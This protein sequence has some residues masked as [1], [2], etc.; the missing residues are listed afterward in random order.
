MF[1]FALISG[2]SFQLNTLPFLEVSITPYCKFVLYS[3][4]L[5]VMN[6]FLDECCLIIF[7]RLKLKIESPYKQTKSS[8]IN[9]SAVLSCPAV[10]NCL[11]DTA[12]SILIP[13]FFPS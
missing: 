8:S 13:N 9:S 10:A 7:L 1:I 12:Y 4:R 11:L 5:I 6:A 2:F 3:F